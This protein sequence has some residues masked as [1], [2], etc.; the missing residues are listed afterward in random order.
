MFGGTFIHEPE[1]SEI[2]HWSAI[3]SQ[4]YLDRV[5]AYHCVA[6]EEGPGLLSITDNGPSS[7][8]T[9]RELSLIAAFR[10]VSC[11]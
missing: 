5:R 2:Y 10:N 8:D 11:A 9:I 6:T 3:S 7:T 1:K 4:Y